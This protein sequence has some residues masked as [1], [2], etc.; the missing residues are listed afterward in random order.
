MWT[1]TTATGK[2]FCNH[3]NVWELPPKNMLKFAMQ[4]SLY[5]NKSQNRGFEM[6]VDVRGSLSSPAHSIRHISGATVFANSTTKDWALAMCQ[7]V[8]I[9]YFIMSLNVST[10]ILPFLQMTTQKISVATQKLQMQNS[11]QGLPET[12]WWHPHYSNPLTHWT[13]LTH[14]DHLIWLLL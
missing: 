13:C 6:A 7:V 1:E 11:D 3:K 4:I 14:S 12:Q 9:C 8:L 10:I 2:L 5:L